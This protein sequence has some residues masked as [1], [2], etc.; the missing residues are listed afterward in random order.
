MIH[1]VPHIYKHVGLFLK[2][3]HMYKSILYFIIPY[4][5]YVGEPLCPL[6]LMLFDNF[7]Y[8][9]HDL[10]VYNETKLK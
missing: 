10:S 1:A 6:L 2:L 8:I 9:F 4:Y 3:L 7:Y 5:Y